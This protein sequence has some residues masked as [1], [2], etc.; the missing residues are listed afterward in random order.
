MAKFSQEFLRQMASPMGSVQ[1]GLLSAVGGAATLP[2][3]L[4]EREKAKALQAELSKL[5]PGSPEYMAALAKSQVGKGMFTEAGATGAAAIQAQQAA[6]KAAKEKERRGRLMGQALQKAAMSD[7]PANNTA[8]VRNMTAEQLM[9]YLTPKKKKDPVQLVQGARLVDPDTNKVLVEAITPQKDQE[10][11]VFELVKSGKW[12]PSTINTDADGN[13]KWNEIK[14]LDKGDEDAPKIPSTVEKEVIRR[15]QEATKSMTAYNRSRNLR[16]SLLEDSNRAAGVLGDFR[17]AVYT[18]GGVRDKNEREKTEFIRQ[19]NSEIITGLPPGVASDTDIAIFSKGLPP[20][21]ANPAEIIAYLEVE[22]KFHAAI[23]DKALIYE[24]HINR[25]KA[26]GN[27]PTTAGILELEF[28]YGSVVTAIEQKLESGEIDE[29]EAKR[30]F[31]GYLGF[32]PTY[33]R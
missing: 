17:T 32:I 23:A 14:P 30:L 8:R 27:T 22:E 3:Q 6:D 9:E 13:I 19:R 10:D 18:L 2:Q 1:G 5:T 15:T 33:Y 24:Q 4:R 21:N 26:E 12:D 31:K 20:E 25:Q 29:Q 11:Q 28:G 16:V 7:D